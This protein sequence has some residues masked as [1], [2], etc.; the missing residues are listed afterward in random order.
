[1]P[2]ANFQVRFIDGQVGGKGMQ[3]LPEASGQSFKEG[4]LVKLVS[5][6]V[7]VCAGASDEAVWGYAKKDASGSADTDILVQRI[8]EGTRLSF[9]VHHDTPASAITAVA[10]VGA[11][12]DMVVAA[13]KCIV[14]IENTTHKILRVVAIDPMYAVGTKYGGLICEILPSHVQAQA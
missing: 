6:K 7:T 8:V 10:Q 3:T 13:N 11:T 2:D 12:Y 5:G 1:M 14:D 9:S 4:Q